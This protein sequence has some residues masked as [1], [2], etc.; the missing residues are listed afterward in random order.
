MQLARQ[1]RKVQPVW[2][3]QPDRR[4]FRVCR[5][6][7]QLSQVRLVRKALPVRLVQRVLPVQ[8]APQVRKVRK[9]QR[10]RPSLLKVKW[11]LSVIYPAG[12]LLTMPISS[13]QMATCMYGM[14]PY[15]LTSVRSWVRK[16]RLARLAHRVSPVRWVV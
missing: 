3:A 9:V 1:V 6:L 8:L 4:V 11:Q 13:P 12:L 10:V 2:Q 16:V 5:V 15:G 7:L 14:G